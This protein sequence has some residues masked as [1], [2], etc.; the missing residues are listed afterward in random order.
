MKSVTIILS[1]LVFSLFVG[2]T[3]TANIAEH[4][5]EVGGN[6]LDEHN[7]CEDLTQE[8][9]ENLDGTYDECADSCRHIESDMC[10]QV[11]VPVCYFD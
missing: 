5:E 6:W 4:C 11:C 2:C 9:C 7:E 1:V 8:Q 3:P 10:I